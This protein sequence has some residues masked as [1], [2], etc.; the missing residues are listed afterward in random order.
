MRT[1]PVTNNLQIKTDR[2]IQSAES[3]LIL[4]DILHELIGNDPSE[5]ILGGYIQSIENC[6]SPESPAHEVLQA[7]TALQRHKMIE[8]GK[9]ADSMQLSELVAALPYLSPWE[10]R[11]YRERLLYLLTEQLPPE[12]LF[13]VVPP[14]RE[15]EREQFEAESS[16]IFNKYI[17]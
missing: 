11:I 6:D 8:Y 9:V 7:A 5:K 14:L 2:I 4:L 15:L 17:K 16:L 12:H 3:P 1:I 13:T 10:Y